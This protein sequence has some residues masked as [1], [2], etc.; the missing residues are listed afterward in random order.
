M[1]SLFGYQ[2]MPH[3]HKSQPGYIPAKEYGRMPVK[4]R[5]FHRLPVYIGNYAHGIIESGRNRY[6][7]ILPLLLSANKNENQTHK[8]FQRLSVH[9]MILQAE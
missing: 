8:G 3:F 1:L 2:I 5:E 7:H 6:S 4:E 9:Q